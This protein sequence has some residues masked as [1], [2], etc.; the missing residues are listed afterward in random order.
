MQTP[1]E[2]AMPASEEPATPKMR[3]PPKPKAVTRVPTGP[4]SGGQS[5]DD[6]GLRMTKP[7]QSENGRRTRRGRPVL[8]G[9][10]RGWRGERAA[11]DE[12]EVTTHERPGHQGTKNVPD[13]EEPGKRSSE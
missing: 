9:R 8:R 5:G 2:Q 12:A 3:C 1:D 4:D 6:E 13:E 7:K 11:A 10:S